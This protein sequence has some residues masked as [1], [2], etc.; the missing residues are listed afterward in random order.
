MIVVNENWN[1]SSKAC[2][3]MMMK[4][5]F[6]D[7]YWN[8]CN[9]TRC[10]LLR[11]PAPSDKFLQFQ[12][13]K[14]KTFLVPMWLFIADKFYVIFLWCSLKRW[15]NNEKNYLRFYLSLLTNKR[16]IGDAH[17]LLKL[18]FLCGFFLYLCENNFLL[19]L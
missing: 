10:P 5:K 15:R 1:V 18:R 11:H 8:L 14:S 3:L 6:A 16:S 17:V 4:W 7:F 19:Q 9:L 2:D 13:L 12:R